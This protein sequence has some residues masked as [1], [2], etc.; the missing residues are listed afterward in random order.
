MMNQMLSGSAVALTELE[1]LCSIFSLQIWED[2]SGLSLW[3]VFTQSSMI[4]S[5]ID[6]DLLTL[7]DR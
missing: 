3:S 6:N 2:I 7:D 1:A 4:T 5:F